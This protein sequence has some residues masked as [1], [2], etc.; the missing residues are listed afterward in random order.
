MTSERVGEFGQSNSVQ[1]RIAEAT[2][3]AL[4]WYDTD[5]TAN[6]TCSYVGSRLEA[7]NTMFHIGQA[8]VRRA[9]TQGATL[10]LNGEKISALVRINL[11]DVPNTDFFSTEMRAKKL[12]HFI[13]NVIL[14]AFRILENNPNLL[15]VRPE[16]FGIRETPQRIWAE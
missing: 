8:F 12:H 16:F 2:R 3:S 14:P 4:E 13:N 1:K 9:D 6:E 7:L 11:Q 5:P 10:V 15:D